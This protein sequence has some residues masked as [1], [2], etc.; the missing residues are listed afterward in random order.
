MNMVPGRIGQMIQ[1]TK[2]QVLR[3]KELGE[4]SIISA[5]VDIN[6]HYPFPGKLLWKLLKNAG[7]YV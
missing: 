3:S 4:Q 1:M 2:K 5:S 6:T 7:E